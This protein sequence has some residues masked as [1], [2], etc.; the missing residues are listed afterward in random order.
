MI[1][2]YKRGVSDDVGVGVK[3][4]EAYQIEEETPHDDSE[5]L[6]E[7]FHHAVAA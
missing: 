7:V 2:I 6:P 5:L 4:A 1:Q 3:Q